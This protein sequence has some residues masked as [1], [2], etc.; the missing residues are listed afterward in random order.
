MNHYKNLNF[1][2]SFSKVYLCAVLQE[3]ALNEVWTP[4]E[5]GESRVRAYEH[6]GS[7]L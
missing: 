7:G 1:Q 5:A 2:V 3:Q 4:Q 6:K